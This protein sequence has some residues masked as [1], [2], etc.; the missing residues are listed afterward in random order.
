MKG[1]T[2]A[3][4]PCLEANPYNR[5][6]IEGLSA[7]GVTVTPHPPQH[8]TNPARSLRWAWHTRL[9]HFHWMQGLYSGRSRWRFAGR[10]C[11]LLLLLAM[12]RLRG[13]QLVLTVHNLVPHDH[14]YRHLHRLTHLGL[15]RLMHC[16]IVHSQP[17]AVAVAAE[18]GVARKIR[19]IE[20]IDYGAPAAIPTRTAA[21][22]L[23]A[24]P[25][26][27]KLLLFFGG[28]RPYKGVDCLIAAAPVVAAIGYDIVIVGESSPATLGATL[29]AAAAA[30]PSVHLRLQRASDREL[31]CYL[32]AADL[33]IFPYRDGLSSGAAHLALA[34]RR[35][36]V[37][38]RSTAF[39]HFI[40]GGIGT[41]LEG[42][43]PEQIKASLLAAEAIDPIGWAC[44]SIAYRRRC[45]AASVAA[46]HR[47][48]YDS[49]LERDAGA[50]ARPPS[51]T[52]Q[53]SHQSSAPR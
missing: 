4:Y 23:L 17:A 52:E 46:R 26:D 24:L 27:R 43:L 15:G 16:L 13:T 53:A 20:H 28:I 42:L 31:S 22:A 10:A 30:H 2:I 49:L 7:A 39:Q 18:Y 11:W 33:V 51:R 8:F 21:R 3:H 34:H 41:P 1:E 6:L 5:L 45:Q 44:A 38:S 40:D 37:C 35:P 19:V 9:V 32:M 36:F 29:T 47:A 14:S 25:A 12:L 50:T 48:L